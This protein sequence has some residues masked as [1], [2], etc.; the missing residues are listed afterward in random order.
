[1][2]APLRQGQ[3]PNHG[4]SAPLDKPHSLYM[5]ILSTPMR[6]E[7]ERQGGHR[8]PGMLSPRVACSATHREGGSG[9]VK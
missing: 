4:A 8:L 7:E 1:M 5:V 6:Q 3:T 9:T 2:S